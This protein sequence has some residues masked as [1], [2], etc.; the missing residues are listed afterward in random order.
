MAYIGY[1]CHIYKIKLFSKFYFDPGRPNIDLPE[2][3]QKNQKIQKSSPESLYVARKEGKAGDT[4]R[5]PKEEKPEILYV[6]QGG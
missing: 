3:L 1:T 6:A 4:L 5:S 2:S